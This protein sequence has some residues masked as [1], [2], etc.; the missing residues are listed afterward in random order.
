MINGIVLY[1]KVSGWYYPKR[2]N[3]TNVFSGR[4]LPEKKV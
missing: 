1:V 3:Q 4:L 2:H